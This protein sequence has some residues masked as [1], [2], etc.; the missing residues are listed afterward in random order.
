MGDANMA[1]YITTCCKGAT[2]EVDDPEAAEAD[3]LANIDNFTIANEKEP[4]IEPALMAHPKA[5]HPAGSNLAVL[6]GAVLGGVFIGAIVAFAYMN[7]RGG[8]ATPEML[9]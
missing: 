9:G 4:C 7:R 6:T 8:V 2:S 1:D 5:A 3:C